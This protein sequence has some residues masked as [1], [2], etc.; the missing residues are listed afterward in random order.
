[1]S[2]QTSLDAGNSDV[3]A[4]LFGP[5]GTRVAGP[6]EVQADWTPSNHPVTVFNSE[7]NTLGVSWVEQ[8][9]WGAGGEC[10]F[11]ETSVDPAAFA[12]VTAPIVVS[13]SA[14]NAWK[15]CTVAWSGSEYGLVWQDWRDPGGGMED[16]Y[17]NRVGCP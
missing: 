6:I 10:M 15:L 17:F 9:D 11:A 14:G 7:S 2:W 5:D 16:I 13:A 3:H 8:S 1:M 4:A 12:V